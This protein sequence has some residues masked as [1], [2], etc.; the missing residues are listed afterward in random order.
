MN[1]DENPL[2][3]SKPDRRRAGARERAQ[4]RPRAGE[5]LVLIYLTAPGSSPWFSS[6]DLNERVV[7]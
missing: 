7:C 4:L 6:F 1:E 5:F 3:E 2:R